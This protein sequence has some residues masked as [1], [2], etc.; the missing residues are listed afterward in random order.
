MKKIFNLILILLTIIP[1]Y[2]QTS[3]Y[4][5]EEEVEEYQP[6]RPL[7]YDEEDEAYYEAYDVN[8]KKPKKPKDTP[9]NQDIYILFSICLVYGLYVIFNETK[10]KTNNE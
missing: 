9:I 2:A 7:D 8:E 6:T 10:T 1:T 3:H 4:D 5:K